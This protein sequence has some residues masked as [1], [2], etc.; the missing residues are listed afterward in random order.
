MKKEEKKEELK[1][2]KREKLYFVL[3]ILLLLILLVIGIS[4]ISVTVT[5]KGD[6]INSIT[7]GRI[8]LDY[9]EDTNGITITNA[10]PMTDESGKAMSGTNQYFDFSVTSTIQGNAAITYEISGQK[11]DTSTLKNN[12]VKLYLEKKIGGEY[13]E[14]MKPQHFVPLTSTTT[15]GSEKGT[16]LLYKNTVDTSK[17]DNYR[18]RMWVDENTKVDATQKIFTV[19]VSLHANAKAKSK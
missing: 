14:V 15:I 17:T 19:Q 1:E 12:E 7:T 5:K 16:M 8:S 10:M 4:A 13:E 9:T 2:E 6:K 18:F 11:Q 3:I